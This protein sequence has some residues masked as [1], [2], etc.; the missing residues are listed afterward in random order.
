MGNLGA[1]DLP[2]DPKQPVSPHADATPTTMATT[3]FAAMTR[4]PRPLATPVN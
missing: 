2:P 3:A 4:R 1:A